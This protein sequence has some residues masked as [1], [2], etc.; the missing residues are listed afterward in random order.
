MKKNNGFVIELDK[1]CYPKEAVIATCCQFLANSYIFLE[2]KDDIRV[3]LTPK[4]GIAIKNLKEKFKE[5]LLNNTL[6][7]NISQRNKDIRDYIVRAALF[8][9]QSRAGADD[10]L[11]SGLQDGSASDWKDDPLGIAIP[12]EEKQ[13]KKK[14]RVAK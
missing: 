5:E 7:Y 4:N 11:L 6:R 14:G 13:V 10:L 2:E 12:C 3:T 8:G 9:V 1:E